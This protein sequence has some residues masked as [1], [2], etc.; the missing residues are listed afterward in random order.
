LTQVVSVLSPVIFPA[1][2][3]IQHDKPRVRSAY[4]RVM[5]LLTFI[6]FPMMLGLV[7]VAKPFVLSVFGEKWTGLIPLIQILSFVGLTQTLCNPTG[8]IYL[9]QGRTD[10]FFWWGV[11]GSGFLVVSIVIG[12]LFGRVESVAWAYLI[13]NVIITIPCIA[14]PGRLI[15]MRVRDVWFSVRGSLFCS[16]LMAVIAWSVGQMLPQGLKPLYQLIIQVALG[17]GA[18]VVFTWILTKAVYREML[19][20]TSRILSKSSPQAVEHVADGLGG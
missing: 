19:G 11:G 2:S 17:V 7:V 12:V 18:Y 6:T 5:R 13:G 3:S 15:D 4:L 16:G 9:S 1:L 14:I 10:W 8:W 20:I